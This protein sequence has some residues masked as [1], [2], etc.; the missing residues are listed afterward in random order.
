MRM[1]YALASLVW[2]CSCG[3]DCVPPSEEAFLAP[4]LYNATRT[5][6][7]DVGDGCVLT[8]VEVPGDRT[9][10]IVLHIECSGAHFTEYWSP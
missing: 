7:P 3:S 9:E 5:M 10:G 2:L 8:Q 1:P 6:G 4:G